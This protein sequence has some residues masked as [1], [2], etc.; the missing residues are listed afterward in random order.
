MRCCRSCP[1]ALVEAAVVAE[2]LRDH[3]EAERERLADWFRERDRIRQRLNECR[4]DPAEVEQGLLFSFREILAPPDQPAWNCPLG[5]HRFEDAD[6]QYL[7]TEHFC[8]KPACAC[9]QVN[10]AFLPIRSD[11]ELPGQY[12]ADVAF[13]AMMSLDGRA[14]L[15]RVYELDEATARR[16]LA[17]WEEDLD[18]VQLKQLTW[19]YEKMREIGRRSMSGY[20]RR[21]P[22]EPQFPPVDSAPTN[23]APRRVGRNDPCP[24]GSGKKYKRCCARTSESALF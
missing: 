1:G 2:F 9:Q 16:V 13:R 4:V 20:T 8:I 6:A 24:C 5:E 22:A 19:R 17:D 7:V 21:Q 11:P 10:L 14:Q 3:P 15:D 12:V 18:A 23:P